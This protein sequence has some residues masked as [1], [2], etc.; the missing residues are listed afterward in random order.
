MNNIEDSRVLMAQPFYAILQNRF[1]KP[2]QE[3]KT[4]VKWS[5]NILP[6]LVPFVVMF[7]STYSYPNPAQEKLAL[8]SRVLLCKLAM[9]N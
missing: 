8:N 1:G 9:S 5:G 3:K 6:T 7:R 4:Q 2:L